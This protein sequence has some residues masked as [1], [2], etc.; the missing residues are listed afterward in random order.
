MT[1]KVKMNDDID[2]EEM[3]ENCLV[4][5]KLIKNSPVLIT[6]KFIKSFYS[7]L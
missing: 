2:L 6:K 4:Y 5:E 3:T 7:K 1:N